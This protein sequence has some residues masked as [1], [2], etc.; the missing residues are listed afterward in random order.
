MDKGNLNATVTESHLGNIGD[1]YNNVL[2]MV[3]NGI[4]IEK[5]CIS[6]KISRSGFYKKI[7]KAQREELRFYKSSTLIYG[8]PGHYPSLYGSRHFM[9]LIEEED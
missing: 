6:A 8:T 4:T 9:T 2:K 1:I 5:A 3:K 7:N